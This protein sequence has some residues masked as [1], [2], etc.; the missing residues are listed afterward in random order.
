[1]QG[2][3]V[4]I[5]ADDP[6]WIEPFSGL[7]QPQFMNVVALLRRWD[8]GV[9]RGRPWRLPLADRVLLVAVYWRTD[10]TLRQV[11]PLFGVSK[12][13]ADRVLDHLAPLLA[14]APARRPRKDTVMIVGGTLVPARDGGA[15]A[16]DRERPCSTSLRVVI[17]TNSRLVVASGTPPCPAQEPD[18]FWGP[19]PRG[20]RRVPGPTGWDP[21]AQTDPH[22]VVHTPVHI[23]A[24][25]LIR[26][27][28]EL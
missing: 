22:R 25:V 8:G 3:D 17:D 14:I 27:D 11:A 5:T 23:P 24:R 18:G 13:A 10:L 6:Q 19:P 26:D 21:P 16:A 28:R 9:R 20:R 1:M 2:V 15:V 7:S 4:V 12:S